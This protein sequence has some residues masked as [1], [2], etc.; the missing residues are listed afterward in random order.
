MSF[1]G[2]ILGRERRA[3]ITSPDPALAEFLGQRNTGGGFVDPARASGLAVAQSCISVISQN[4]SAMPLNL[5]QRSENSGRTRATAYPMYTVLHDQMNDQM[6]A[7]E[8]REFLIVSLL[9]SGNAYA[10]IETNGQGR[11][12][13]LHPIHPANMTVERLETGRLRYIST[14]QRGRRTVHIQDEILHVR[15]RLAPDGVMGVSPIHLARETFALALTQQDQASKQAARSFRT[16]GALVFPN[17]IS[18][19]KKDSALDKL[20]LRIE[21]QVETSGLLVLDGGVDYKPLSL[22]SKDAS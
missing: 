8:G 19:D 14:T 1:L 21:G 6:T 11:V 22:S 2:R 5:Y 4:L 7:F 17:P 12:V 18:G 16:E 9:T 10:R 15:Y 3:T 20:R 13:A